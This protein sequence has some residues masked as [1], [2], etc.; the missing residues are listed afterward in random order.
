MDTP[1]GPYHINEWV[2]PKWM[3]ESPRYA[4]TIQYLERERLKGPGF[5]DGGL[6]TTSSTPAPLFD[7]ED[8]TRNK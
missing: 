3:N 5:F 7:D 1:K 2:S 4:P 8:S 6:N